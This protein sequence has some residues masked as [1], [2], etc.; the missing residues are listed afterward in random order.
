MVGAGCVVVVLGT[1]YMT[2]PGILCLPTKSPEYGPYSMGCMVRGR[3]TSLTRLR[4][5]QT[6]FQRRGRN[7]AWRWTADLRLCTIKYPPVN[8]TL[9][10]TVLTPR[11]AR[12]TY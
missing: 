5:V 8:H 1:G 4:S 2:C 6:C 12:G 3:S 11:W 7:P 10:L 9:A